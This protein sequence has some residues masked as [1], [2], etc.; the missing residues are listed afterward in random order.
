MKIINLKR[1]FKKN[2]L[3]YMDSKKNNSNDLL[4]NNIYFHHM[5]GTGGNSFAATLANSNPNYELIQ[6]TGNSDYELQNKKNLLITNSNVRRLFYGHNLFK[7]LELLGIDQKYFTLLRNPIDRL[8]TDYFWLKNKEKNMNA[9]KAL[10]S[11]YKFVESTEHLEFYIHHL[12]PL[13]FRNK[14]HFNYQECS[15]ISNK[16]AFKLACQNLKEKFWMVGIMELFEESLFIASKEIKIKKLAP[17]WENRHPK[18][19]Y[20]PQFCDFPQRIRKILYNKM[21]F[22]FQLYEL[23]R[24]KLEDQFKNI[25]KTGFEDYFNQA[26]PLKEIKKASST[27]IVFINKYCLLD[28]IYDFTNKKRLNYEI[29]ITEQ[30]LYLEFDLLALNNKSSATIIDFSHSEEQGFALVLNQ[31]KNSKKNIDLILYSNYFSLIDKLEI[32]KWSTVKITVNLID[33]NFKLELNGNIQESNYKT[34]NLFLKKNIQMAIGKMVNNEERDFYG[35]IKNLYVFGFKI[36]H[37]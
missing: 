10:E 8:I 9:Y 11:F 27:N 7:L 24:K 16:N 4:I 26:R 18:T 21:D 12:G 37:F 30:I 13:D 15:S 29:K 2:S 17:W 28:K 6:I 22:D 14:Q 36:D 1:I 23:N 34:E 25:S 33:K 19:K 32:N 31:I 3:T 35:S 20:R 5:V